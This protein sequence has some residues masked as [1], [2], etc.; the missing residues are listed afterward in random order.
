M[1]FKVP[2]LLNLRTNQQVYFRAIFK[3]TLSDLSRLFSLTELTRKRY[4][5]IKIAA[6]AGQELK[7]QHLNTKLEAL[8]ATGLCVLL[9]DVWTAH[10]QE[11][12]Q[13]FLLNLLLLSD[14]GTSKQGIVKQLTANAR[15]RLGTVPNRLCHGRDLKT[16]RS[17]ESLLINGSWGR[18]KGSHTWPEQF[19]TNLFGI[20]VTRYSIGS[21]QACVIGQL[22][23]NV[24]IYKLLYF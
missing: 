8:L 24:A 12:L 13:F 9:R 5:A 18:K 23:M 7:K 1:R 20:L 3:A 11:S 16:S 10:S 19:Q 4:L 2:L 15:E 17:H 6:L 14:V 21:Q 22:A